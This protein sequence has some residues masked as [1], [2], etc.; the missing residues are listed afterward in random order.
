M[1]FWINQ[2]EPQQ[3]Y[4]V[5][6]EPSNISSFNG[7]QRELT[8]KPNRF[9]GKKS[10]FLLQTTT[11][12]HVFLLFKAQEWCKDEKRLALRGNASVARVHTSS[13]SPHGE[14]SKA[15][16]VCI[17]VYPVYQKCA[18]INI[19]WS[20]YWILL[21][22]I[23]YYYVYKKCTPILNIIEYCQ[24]YLQTYVCVCV[25]QIFS[26]LTHTLRMTWNQDLCTLDLKEPNCSRRMRFGRHAM[27]RQSRCPKIQRDG[28]V[29]Q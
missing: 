12:P 16:C 19:C 7:F 17:R 1:C 24:P 27:L 14:T 21:N 3:Y 2:C 28:E 5:N 10:C 11:N 25:L 15:R 22:V 8:W 9:H 18:S 6:I 13:P 20:I 4:R 26:E 23:E 29:G